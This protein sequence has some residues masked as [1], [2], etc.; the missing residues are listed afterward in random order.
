MAEKKKGTRRKYD[1]YYDTILPSDFDRGKSGKVN[2][3]TEAV[4]KALPVAA[5]AVV[6]IGVCVVILFVL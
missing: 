4:K 5:G 6:L 2:I 1:G 3:N